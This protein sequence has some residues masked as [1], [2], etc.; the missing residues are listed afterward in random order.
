MISAIFKLQ[1]NRWRNLRY[2][3]TIVIP[4]QD[5]EPRFEEPPRQPRDKNLVTGP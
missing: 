5:I 4:Y 3:M 2:Q 1:K